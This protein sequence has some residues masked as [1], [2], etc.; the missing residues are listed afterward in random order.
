MVVEMVWFQ[1]V[2]YKAGDQM[3]YGHGSRFG[4]K[5]S[6]GY[7]GS[8]SLGQFRRGIWNKVN[9]ETRW[10]EEQHIQAQDSEVICARPR[11]LSNNMWHEEKG[12]QSSKR[13]KV[14]QRQETIK[15]KLH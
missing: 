5:V 10:G 4:G 7:K 1:G 8:G 12:R 14:M 9:H 6:L 15:C 3:I 13:T 2:E 11:V